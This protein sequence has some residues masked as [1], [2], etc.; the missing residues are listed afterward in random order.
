MGKGVMK[1]YFDTCCYCRPYDNPAH[2]AQERVRLE[3]AAIL[4]TV[5]LCGISGVPIYGSASVV[6]ELSFIK[7][8]EKLKRVRSF[9][10]EFITDELELTADISIRAQ[11]I[12]AQKIDLYDA[13]HVAFAESIGASYL[14]TTDYRFENVAA[15]LNLKTVVINP[16]NF[17]GEYL[18]WRL[19]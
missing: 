8:Q 5:R 4:D 19:S 16:I 13:F 11:K 3:V 2:M 12:Q 6:A 10:N 1:L 18:L 9:Y 15:R 7:E 14:L 17:L